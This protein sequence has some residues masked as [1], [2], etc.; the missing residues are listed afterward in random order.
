M[1]NLVLAEVKAEFDSVDNRYY[2][3]EMHFAIAEYLTLNG[4]KPCTLTTWRGEY[5]EW[6]ADAIESSSFT[7]IFY[8]GKVLSRYVRF[9]DSLDH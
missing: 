8:A 7:E 9:I 6:R 5:G 2:A 3:L 4:I 1:T